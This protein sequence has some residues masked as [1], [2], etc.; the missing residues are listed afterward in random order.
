MSVNSNFIVDIKTAIVR[1]LKAAFDD[2]DYPDEEIRG[3]NISIEYPMKE[4]DYPH[5]WVNFSID[6]LQDAGLGH[7]FLEEGIIKREF[8]FWGTIRFNI[9]TLSSKERDIYASQL[10]QML[11]FRNLN[12]IAAQFDEYLDSYPNLHMTIDRDTLLVQGQSVTLGTPWDE[13]EIAY[14]DGYAIKV[15]GQV[16]SHFTVTPEILSKIIIEST[17]IVGEQRLP[18]VATDAFETNVDPGTWV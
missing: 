6:K 3:I 13:K 4:M 10:V 9:V 2:V 7:F 11:A 5:L 8:M 12:P 15:M 18:T 17:G 1:A 16:E 14:E